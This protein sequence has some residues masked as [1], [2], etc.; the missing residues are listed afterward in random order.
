[1]L[2]RVWDLIRNY[3][4]RYLYLN[5]FGLFLDFEKKI[6]KF[7]IKDNFLNYISFYIILYKMNIDECSKIFY[8]VLFIFFFFFG[9]VI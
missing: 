1:M 4:D 6:L 9:V 3:E 5:Y 7:I 2:L 8:Y